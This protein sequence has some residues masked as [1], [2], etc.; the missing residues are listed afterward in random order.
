M[1]A[2]LIALPLAMLTGCA[3]MSAP[4]PRLLPADLGVGTLDQRTGFELDDSH[5]TARAPNDAP[6]DAV[7]TPKKKRRRKVLF[8]LGLGGMGFGALGVTGFGI[9][10][11]ITQGQLTRGYEDGDITR[12]EADSL[13]TRGEVL[14]GLT[15]GS[16]AIGVIG[17][18]LA[19]TMY[20]IDHARCGDL[21]PRRDECPGRDDDAAASSDAP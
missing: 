21:P 4:T 20:G 7:E 1:H 10:G 3:T 19:A 15:I 12:G 5:S 16:A 13:S 14:N 2:R 11:R 17:T 9:G 6:D 18:V 8:F